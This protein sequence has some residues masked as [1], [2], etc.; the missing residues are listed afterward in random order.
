MEWE[1]VFLT[2]ACFFPVTLHHTKRGTPENY[3]KEGKGGGSVW[4]SRG[5]RD[6]QAVGVVPSILGRVNCSCD[7]KTLQPAVSK[8]L[9]WGPL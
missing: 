1:D 8:V 6:G 2:I 5:R 3:Y 7:Y 4:P 9:L